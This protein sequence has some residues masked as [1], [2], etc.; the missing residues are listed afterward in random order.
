MVLVYDSRQSSLYFFNN[1]SVLEIDLLK[2]PLF[3]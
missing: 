1:N 3:C 2:V